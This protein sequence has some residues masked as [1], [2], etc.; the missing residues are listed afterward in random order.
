MSLSDR[1]AGRQTDSINAGKQRQ[2]YIFGDR[3]CGF[4]LQSFKHHQAPLDDVMSEF[5]PTRMLATA[6]PVS[7][8][9]PFF[10][11]AAA[12]SHKLRS[13]ILAGNINLVKILLGSEL[14]DRHV[15]DSGDISIALKD[16]DPRLAK[17]LTFAEFSVA[18]SV[19]REVLCEVYPAR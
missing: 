12:I 17:T 10:P 2:A 3:L 8:G 18:F 13:Q 7:H 16:A 11:P 19:Y 5:T 4:N 14:C 9:Q 1:Q 6:V 15:V